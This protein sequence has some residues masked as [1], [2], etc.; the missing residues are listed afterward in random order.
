MGSL[1]STSPPSTTATRPPL[2]RRREAP[3]DG[4]LNIVTYQIVSSRCIPNGFNP[5]TGLYNPPPAASLTAAAK[6]LNYDGWALWNH[7]FHLQASDLLLNLCDEV[8][9]DGLN[10]LQPSGGCAGWM[11]QIRAQ[12]DGYVETLST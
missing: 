12:V 8:F 10:A 5:Q 2:A 11:A 6:Q 1:R 7:L 3:P 9:F 4:K